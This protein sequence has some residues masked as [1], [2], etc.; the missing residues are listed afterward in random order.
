VKNILTSLRRQIIKNQNQ[1]TMKYFAF[2]MVLFLLA[3][4]NASNTKE[5][6]L[7]RALPYTAAYSSNWSTNVSDKDLNTVL[8]TYKYWQDG[9]IKALANTFGD[10]LN[11]ES[12]EGI[13][14]KLTHQDVETLWKPLRDSIDKVDIRMESWHKM[15]STDK[16]QA[17]VVT[18]Y[19]E[20]DTFKNGKVDSANYHDINMIENGK[21]VWYS[22]YKRPF[23]K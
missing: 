22:Q 20:T 5:K 21:I 18:W 2:Y 13:N 6:K 14:Y 10:T 9:N 1:Q 4:N 7:T 15:Y 16:K 12:W 3:C 19:V 11:F 8:L 17:F 23:K